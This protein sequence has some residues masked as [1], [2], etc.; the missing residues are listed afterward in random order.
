MQ[1]F[2][3]AVH[4]N[5][6]AS[7]LFIQAIQSRCENL[8]TV[9]LPG[10]TWCQ[11]VLFCAEKCTVGTLEVPLPVG[12]ILCSCCFPLPAP[13]HHPEEDASV[14]GR[15]PPQ[16]VGRRAN[17]VRGQASVHPVPG[18][19]S[20]GRHPGLSPGG[21]AFG[22]KFT[23]TRKILTL[24]FTESLAEQVGQLA[25]FFLHRHSV[26]TATEGNTYKI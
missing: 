17:A 1:D 8:S 3:S 12:K 18:A 2:I 14:L 22:R 24:V 21:D 13:A 5:S 9:S 19:G 4:R 7:G 10:A 6:A 26:H 15:D 25:G 20:H 23:G 16:P 11:S